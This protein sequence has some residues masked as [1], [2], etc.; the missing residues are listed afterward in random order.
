M[1][2]HSGP[3]RSAATRHERETIG[4]TNPVQNPD[5]CTPL[6]SQLWVAHCGFR[7]QEVLIRYD[8]HRAEAS[9]LSESGERLLAWLRV[10][11]DDPSA[12]NTPVGS[13]RGSF[14]DHHDHATNLRTYSF[15]SALLLL[16]NAAV[17]H[18]TPPD[19][20]NERFRLLTQQI[21]LIDDLIRAA[22]MAQQYRP[23]GSLGSTWALLIAWASLCWRQPSHPTALLSKAASFEKKAEIQTLLFQ[24]EIVGINS[25][26]HYMLQQ[27]EGMFERLFPS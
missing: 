4:L 14:A 27:A 26:T 23:L 6:T 15:A 21:N 17:L 10:R 9:A 24:Y 2:D 16:L 22:K 11:I 3:V 7:I 1:R 18:R 12:C 13:C 25:R 19:D 8:T 20:P 5:A